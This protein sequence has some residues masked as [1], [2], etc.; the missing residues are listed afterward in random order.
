[1]CPP[2]PR[3]TVPGVQTATGL[4]SPSIE[5]DASRNP[6][7]PFAW[8]PAMYGPGTRR[9]GRVLVVSPPCSD[10]NMPSLIP[11][12]F[13]AAFQGPTSAF[14]HPF[15]LVICF[16]RIHHS[17]LPRRRGPS[18]ILNQHRQTDT[19]VARTGPF[20]AQQLPCYSVLVSPSPFILSS[21]PPRSCYS[22]SNSPSYSFLS[23]L[24]CV[25][26]AESS[27]LA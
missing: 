2:Q 6:Q 8:P 10:V 19:L 17:S 25:L 26:A 20:H 23:A 13:P 14:Q 1:M 27:A 22:F 24:M 4:F 18:A 5:M 3:T 15:L 11:P 9:F 16:T 7:T 21:P 12:A